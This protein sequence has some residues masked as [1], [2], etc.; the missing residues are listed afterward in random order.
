[1]RL[2]RKPVEIDRKDMQ[3][4]DVFYWEGVRFKCRHKPFKALNPH[5]ITVLTRWYGIRGY[6]NMIGYEKITVYR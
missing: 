4:G 1:M 3:V 5:Y 2:F 6:V